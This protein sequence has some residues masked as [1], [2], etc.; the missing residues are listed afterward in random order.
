MKKL[1]TIV[2]FLCNLSMYAQQDTINKEDIFGR[3]IEDT[4]LRPDS[5][6]PHYTYIFRENMIFH[7]G[8]AFDGVIIFNI[9]GKYTYENN[10]ISV[11]Y[12]D[13]INGNPKDRKAYYISFDVLS[14]ENNKMTLLAKDSGY[15]YKIYLKKLLK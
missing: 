9:T 14:L 12:F 4:Q 1:L 15:N 7:L 10:S 5:A 3:W 6:T 8:E 13:L 2:L 11:V